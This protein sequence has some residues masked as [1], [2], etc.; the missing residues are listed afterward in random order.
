MKTAQKSSHS[1]CTQRG[2]GGGQGLC[3]VLTVFLQIRNNCRVKEDRREER[4][5]RLER[6][7]EKGPLLVLTLE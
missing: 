4:R 1:R 2:G 5:Q 3:T 7:G 6:L